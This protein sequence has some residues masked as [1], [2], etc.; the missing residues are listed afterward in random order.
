MSPS[1]S[2]AVQ[3]QKL[4]TAQR[5]EVSD[6]VD[7]LLTRRRQ[8]TRENKR[9]VWLTKVSVWSDSDVK[10]IEEAMAEVNNWK[11]PSF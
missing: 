5:K 7:F 6:F 3:M 10:P 9:K 2:V 1:A 8:T 11:L 4:N